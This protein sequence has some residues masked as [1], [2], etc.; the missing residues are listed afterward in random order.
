MNGDRYVENP[1]CEWGIIPI[2]WETG[3]I[4]LLKRCSI[5]IIDS[6]LGRNLEQKLKYGNLNHHMDS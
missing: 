6:L 4:F 1:E 3:F 2:A 5:F